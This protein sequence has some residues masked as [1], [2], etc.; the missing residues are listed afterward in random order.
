MAASLADAAAQEAARTADL[1][2]RVAEMTEGARVRE[3]YR[4]P[5]PR[6]VWVTIACCAACSARVVVRAAPE[7][8][9]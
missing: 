5:T 9:I 8:E 2:A 6:V 3:D 7:I 1:T 4:V